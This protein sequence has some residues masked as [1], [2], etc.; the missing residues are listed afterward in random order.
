MRH[1]LCLFWI[2]LAPSGFADTL[3]NKSL[4]DINGDDTVSAQELVTDLLHPLGC[5]FL[6][7]SAG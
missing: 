6:Y 3:A 1:W 2:L 5:R 4:G 7:R